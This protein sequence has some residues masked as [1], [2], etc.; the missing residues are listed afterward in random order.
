ML[1]AVVLHDLEHI[2]QAHDRHSL[3]VAS[4]AQPGR[5]QRAGEVLL[6]GVSSR[7][8]AGGLLRYFGMK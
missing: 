8:V 5:Q 3:D 2:F 7:A 4:L 1:A 6:I